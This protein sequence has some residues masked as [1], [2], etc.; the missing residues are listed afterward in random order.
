MQVR[1]EEDV[2][3]CLKYVQESQREMESDDRQQIYGETARGNKQ[4]SGERL[5]VHLWRVSGGAQTDGCL[6]CQKKEIETLCQPTTESERSCPFG[7]SEFNLCS[8]GTSDFVRLNPGPY[9]STLSQWIDR[10]GKGEGKAE[11]AAGGGFADNDSLP[12]GQS[13]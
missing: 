4:T 1:R 12:Q 3:R 7:H 13:G 8:V 11:E 2:W 5:K 9:L 6:N 10:M